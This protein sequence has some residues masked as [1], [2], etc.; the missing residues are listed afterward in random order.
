[1][2][3]QHPD[4][5]RNLMCKA[6]LMEAAQSTLT[7]SVGR[8]NVLLRDEWSKGRDSVSGMH[9][10]GPLFSSHSRQRNYMPAAGVED[11]GSCKFALRAL[12]P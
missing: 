9:L 1:V 6:P 3:G 8:T 4:T 10:D 12:L 2:L 7:I 11:G 5:D